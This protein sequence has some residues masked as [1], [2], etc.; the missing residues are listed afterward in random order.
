MPAWLLALLVPVILTGIMLSVWL[1]V[2]S[3][4]VRK[5]FQRRKPRIC[6]NLALG[7]GFLGEGMRVLSGGSIIPNAPRSVDFGWSIMALISSAIQ[8]Y[9]GWKVYRG[10]NAPDQFS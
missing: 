7:F 9:S 6:L 8:F 5:L 1:F 10:K 3:D 4:G 2:E